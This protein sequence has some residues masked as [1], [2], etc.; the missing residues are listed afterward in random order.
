MEGANVGCLYAPHIL[1]LANNLKEGA[2]ANRKSNGMI[3]G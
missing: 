3:T 1:R 2:K